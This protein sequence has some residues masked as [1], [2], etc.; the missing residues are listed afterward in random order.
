MGNISLISY[1]SIT[2][3]YNDMSEAK[4]TEVIDLCMKS[5]E[6]ISGYLPHQAYVLVNVTN[7]RF[8]SQV[9]QFIKETTKDNSPFVKITAV[10]GLEGFTKPLLDVVA[11][12]SDRTMVIVDSFEEGLEKLFLHSTA[13]D[14]LPATSFNLK[15]SG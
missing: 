11:D 15:S 6:I 4:P 3:V 2:L 1:K 5:K 14:D 8:N 13:Q 12:Y 9:V 10:F 7:I